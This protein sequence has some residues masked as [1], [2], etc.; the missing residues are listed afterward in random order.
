MNY[1]IC[2]LC[3]ELKASTN[4]Q[5]CESCTDEYKTI[6]THIEK[7]PK[8]TVLE[9]STETRVSLKRINQLVEIGR[10]TLVPNEGV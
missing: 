3:N 10:F 1:Q 7:N 5:I 4:N 2:R 9:I 8:S 6:R